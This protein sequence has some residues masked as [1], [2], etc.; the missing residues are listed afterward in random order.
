MSVAVTTGGAAAAASDPLSASFPGPS[1]AP[2]R[3][4]LAASRAL[5]ARGLL[6]GAMPPL[7]SALGREIRAARAALDASDLEAATRHAGRVHVLGSFSAVTH[8]Y[9]HYVHLRVDL[10]RRA[11]RAAAIQAVRLV[12]TA[13]T[14][15]IVPFIGVT[16]HPGTSDR[17]AGTRWPIEPELKAILDAQPRP[18]RRWPWS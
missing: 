6:D 14:R 13:F 8:A 18:A 11:F 1:G 17:A 12:G 15:P 5:E 10:R 4:L 16:G 7:R 2:T 9:S 3:A